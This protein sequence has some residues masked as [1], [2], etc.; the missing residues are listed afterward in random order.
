MEL[1]LL[2][3]LQATGK[4][5]FYKERFFSTH[6]RINLDMLK[7]RFRERTLLQACLATR[8]KLVVDNTNL[9]A[10]DRAAYIIPAKQAKFAVVGY[11][12]RSCLEEC[13]IRNT[14][15]QERERLPNKALL[16][17]YGRLQIPAYDEGYDRLHYVSL[18]SG[19]F[20]I[21]E[22]RDEV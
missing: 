15:R 20:V 22:W 5:T 12:F 18:V 13:L 2:T 10:T 1:I 6:V 3:G 19:E 7:T 17:A 21:E 16:G 4:S 9:T 8:Q 11:Y 14:A